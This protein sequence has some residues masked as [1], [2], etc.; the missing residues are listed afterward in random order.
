[1]VSAALEAAEEL[2]RQRIGARVLDMHTVKPCD[3]AAVL[4]AA[5]ETGH[6]VVAEEHLLHGGLGSAVAMSAARQHPVPIRFIGLRD[7][8]AESGKPEELLAKYGLTSRDIVR[9]S[10]AVLGRSV[11]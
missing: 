3:D 8:F 11:R 2:A 5:R 10:L 4:A 1:M 6:L 7:T 9:E